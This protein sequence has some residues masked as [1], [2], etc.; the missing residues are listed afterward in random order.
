MATN[1]TEAVYV[2]D[3]LLPASSKSAICL[4][5]HVPVDCD[6]DLLTSLPSMQPRAVAAG[7]SR[8]FWRRVP[9]SRSEDQ[10][11]RP[12]MW[13][14]YEVL[15][16]GSHEQ[17]LEQVAKLVEGD[18]KASRFSSAHDVL[19]KAY[20]PVIES[21]EY[22]LYRQ[23]GWTLEQSTALLTAVNTY[24]PNFEVI[25]DRVEH[26]EIPHSPD[27]MRAHF[28]FLARVSQARACK[29]VQDHA[30]K[31]AAPTSGRHVPIVELLRAGSTSGLPPRETSALLA[32]RDAG[33]IATGFGPWEDVT[34]SATY[35]ELRGRR[36]KDVLRVL[37]PAAALSARW[38]GLEIG[39][40]APSHFEVSDLEAEKREEELRIAR[41]RPAVGSE[42][43]RLG[44]GRGDICY[45]RATAS[46]APREE[47]ADMVDSKPFPRFMIPALPSL[48]TTCHGPSTMYEGFFTVA[49]PHF[50]VETPS[51]RVRPPVIDSTVQD[52]ASQSSVAFTGT[53]VMQGRGRAADAHVVFGGK[54]RS[55]ALTELRD[56]VSDHDSIRFDSSDPEMSRQ[57]LTEYSRSLLDALPEELRC[58]FDSSGR[59][60]KGTTYIDRILRDIE[61]LV[62]PGGFLVR[63]LLLHEVLEHRMMLCLLQRRRIRLLREKLAKLKQK[64]AAAAE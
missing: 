52:W 57:M 38:A 56:R 18:T 49:K 35:A 4:T 21:D 12:N 19:R 62:K 47:P 41:L 15:S 7:A 13:R 44:R 64:S 46:A 2:K 10:S 60:T 20:L 31:A 9:T 53:A 8:T 36:V 48:S 42:P 23:S 22:A 32:S 34:Y 54:L 14:K 17:D 29:A 30:V 27:E 51:S 55:W 28:V 24:G 33:L 39:A 16:S 63:D 59:L 6:T 3:L 25:S 37:T 58:D 40:V 1:E 11:W 26:S 5:S 45:S 43:R 61:D 50:I